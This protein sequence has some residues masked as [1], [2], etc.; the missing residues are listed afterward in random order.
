M[1]VC[2][3]RVDGGDDCLSTA[4]H[5]TVWDAHVF[6]LNAIC[7]C[8]SDQ[9]AKQT[10]TNTHITTKGVRKVKLNFGYIIHTVS[11]TT[12]HTTKLTRSTICFHSPQ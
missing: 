11:R 2:E 9:R 8:V 4:A 3:N 6:V 12:L 5:D 7:Q 10:H 1:N